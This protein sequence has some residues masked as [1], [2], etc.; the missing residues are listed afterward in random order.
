[1]KL[2]VGGYDRIGRYVLGVVL[3][4]VGMAAPLSAMWQTVVF[5]VA[6]IALLTA[7]VQYCPVNHLFGINTCKLEEKK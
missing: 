1:M 3:L 2:N 5:V 7:A 6:A 4:L